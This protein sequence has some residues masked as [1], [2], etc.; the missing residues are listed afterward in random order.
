MAVAIAIIVILA[1]AVGTVIV[2]V[3]YRQRSNTVLLSRET[4]HRDSATGAPAEVT[5][6]T[7]TELETTGRERADDTRA[8]YENVPAKR[9]R[10]DVVV[11]EPVDEEELGVSRRQFLNR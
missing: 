5:E 6:S 2:L 3:G 8:T 11:Y 7:S 1:L 9:K 4:K 10:G